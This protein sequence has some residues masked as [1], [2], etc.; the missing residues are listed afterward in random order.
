MSDKASALGDAL[1]RFDRKERRLVVS[2]ALGRAAH[3]LDQDF[4]DQVSRGA[5]I[6]PLPAQ[7]TRWFT[8]YHFDWLAGALRVYAYGEERCL[9]RPVENAGP[10]P[11]IQGN[12][13]DID[14]LL[15][16]GTDL[17]LVEAKWFGGWSSRQLESKLHRLGR[18]RRYASEA[19]RDAGT[20]EVHIHFLLMSPMEPPAWA[21]AIWRAHGAGTEL[22][23]LPMRAPAERTS[24]LVV[25]RCNP[26][27]KSSA[28]GTHWQVAKVGMPG[29]SDVGSLDGFLGT[30][31]GPDRVS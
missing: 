12:Q 5:N 14:L 11:L 29:S 19:C 22:G 6:Q 8:D 28:T 27:G 7:E 17:V 16:R 24:A 3:A 18:L 20:D 25:T 31:G 2:T 30:D 13:Q 4:C 21:K 10:E 15:V 23:W 9:D 26:E 1:T